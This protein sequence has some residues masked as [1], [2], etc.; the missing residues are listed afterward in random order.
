LR[1]VRGAMPL[2]LVLE[3]QS[4]LCAPARNTVE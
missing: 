1:T 4:M 2:S 3:E